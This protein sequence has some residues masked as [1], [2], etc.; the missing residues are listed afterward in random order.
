MKQLESFFTQNTSN[1]EEDYFL[2]RHRIHRNLRCWANFLKTQSTSK[3]NCRFKWRAYSKSTF[4][5]IKQKDFQN[6]QILTPKFTQR[7]L[8]Y[9][10]TSLTRK[11][12]FWKNYSSNNEEN[13]YKIRRKLI[14]RILWIPLIILIQL[15]QIQ[16]Q[17]QME[18]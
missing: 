3:P 17:L 5:P 8:K 4:F 9:E 1:Q 13:I 6:L 14:C 15:I 18:E 2:E 7:L 10:T 12:K 16:M 11:R